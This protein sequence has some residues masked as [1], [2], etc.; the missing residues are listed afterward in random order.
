MNPC[1]NEEVLY[2][3]TQIRL[4]RAIPDRK[5]GKNWTIPNNFHVG[6]GLE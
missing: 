4:L 5:L 1:T 6:E 3:N 2:F